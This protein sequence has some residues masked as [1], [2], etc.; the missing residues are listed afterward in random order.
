MARPA[1]DRPVGRPREFDE[2]TVLEAAMEAFWSKGYEA[3]SLAELCTCM[4]LNKGS[5]YQ[6]FGDKHTL[7]MRALKAYA[8][9][10][11]RETAAVAF[12]SVSTRCASSGTGVTRRCEPRASCADT[13]RPPYESSRP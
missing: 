1:T 4:G 10:E 9:R 8:D 2:D 6:A 13:T 7:F 11:F 12:D 3:T 5:L